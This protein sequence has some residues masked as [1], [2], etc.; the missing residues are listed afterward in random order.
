MYTPK[1]KKES[2]RQPQRPPLG[3]TIAAASGCLA[4]SLGCSA[5]SNRGAAATG[6]QTLG[7]V[8]CR[9]ASCPRAVHCAL[10]RQFAQLHA[11]V[12][13]V[14]TA[15]A[16]PDTGTPVCSAQPG[17]ERAIWYLISK[18]VRTKQ[19]GPS[20]CA[21]SFVGRES[22]VSIL[23]PRR[24]PGDNEASLGPGKLS[25]S[26]LPG[27]QPEGWLLQ[28]HELARRLFLGGG[29]DGAVFRGWDRR[30]VRSLVVLACDRKGREQ[31][32]EHPAPSIAL[33]APHT[34]R[35]RALLQTL[36]GVE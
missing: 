2:D 12:P 13:H 33:R 24:P 9:D 30:V 19:E 28:G 15:P 27:Q 26:S 34:S 29:F 22:V 6:E 8:P 36:P 5:L 7:H 10:V 11:H 3:L 32:K 4:C 21:L 17:A 31:H 20:F 25:A 18:R 14:R 16:R 1:A 35:L 23:R